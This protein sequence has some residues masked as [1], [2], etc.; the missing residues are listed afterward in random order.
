MQNGNAVP[1]ENGGHFV[2]DTDHIAG[3]V[4]GAEGAAGLVFLSWRH[5][6][7]F[8]GVAVDDQYLRAILAQPRAETV[9]CQFGG[10]HLTG[11]CVFNVDAVDHGVAFFRGGHHRLGGYAVVS[12]GKTVKGNFRGRTDER[13]LRRGFCVVNRNIWLRFLLPHAGN[14]G[15]PL[16]KEQR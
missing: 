3:G 6:V 8:G 12:E 9:P 4:S 11:G 14:D 13:R 7:G 16:L 15:G 2:T 10:I 1:G 5:G